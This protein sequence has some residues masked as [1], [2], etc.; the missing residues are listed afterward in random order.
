MTAIYFLRYRDDGNWHTVAKHEYVYME[1]MCGLRNRTG[2]IPYEP[3]TSSFVYGE[4]RGQIQVIG[5]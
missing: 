3:V 1:R 4:I 2:V 5:E